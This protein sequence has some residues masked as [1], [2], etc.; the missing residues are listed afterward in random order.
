MAH[1]M[2]GFLVAAAGVLLC[3]LWLPAAGLSQPAGDAAKGRGP[4]EQ[5]C[6]VCHG[7]RGLGNGPMAKATSPPAPRLASSDVRRLTDEELFRTIADGKGSTMPAW[8]GILNDEQ[9]RDV[10]AYIRLLGS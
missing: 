10:V 4:Y 2:R 9:L 3:S 8:R 5:Y 6:A 7:A 1:A